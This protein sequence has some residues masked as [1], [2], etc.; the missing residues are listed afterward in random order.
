MIYCICFWGFGAR[1]IN[2]NHIWINFWVQTIIEK[3]I[4]KKLCSIFLN[5]TNVNAKSFAI[6]IF[7]LQLF[8]SIEFSWTFVNNSSNHHLVLHFSNQKSNFQHKFYIFH[9]FS[10]NFTLKKFTRWKKNDFNGSGAKSRLS[11]KRKEN[12]WSE[13][14]SLEKSEF[15]LESFSFPFLPSYVL[16]EI[17]T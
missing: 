12:L 7:L 3:K 9:F 4:D 14:F 1:K 16:N 17:A 5:C 6:E 13:K 10:F 2:S 15:A 8:L 11:W